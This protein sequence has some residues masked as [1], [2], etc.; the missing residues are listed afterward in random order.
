M[1]GEERILEAGDDLVLF[2]DADE[3]VALDAR[4]A[5]VALELA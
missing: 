1:E 4:E 3:R 2:S 5:Q